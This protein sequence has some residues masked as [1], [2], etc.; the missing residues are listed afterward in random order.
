VRIPIFDVL[1]FLSRKKKRAARF[2]NANA[3]NNAWQSRKMAPN[4]QHR[5]DRKSSGWVPLHGFSRQRPPTQKKAVA[6]S[7]ASRFVV[8]ENNSK[9]MCSKLRQCEDNG[10]PQSE[11]RARA[12]LVVMMTDK[13][14]TPCFQF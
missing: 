6:S 5:T 3:E 10:Q 1:S 7:R 14:R 13:G 4:D 8:F 2:G 12:S 9:N 11:S